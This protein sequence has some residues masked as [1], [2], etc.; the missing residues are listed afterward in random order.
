LIGNGAM[1][2]IALWRL[3]DAVAELEPALE[4][5]HE[6]RVGLRAHN[7]KLVLDNDSR[8]GPARERRRTMRCHP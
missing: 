4:S 1:I 6:R 7:E 5:G 2:R 3:L 8:G